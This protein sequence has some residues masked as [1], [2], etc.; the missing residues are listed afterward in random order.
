MLLV[1]QTCLCTHLLRKLKNERH[2]AFDKKNVRSVI[3][4]RTKKKKRVKREFWLIYETARGIQST[5]L[6]FFDVL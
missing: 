1:L 6:Q 3:A 5:G 2:V 4:Y